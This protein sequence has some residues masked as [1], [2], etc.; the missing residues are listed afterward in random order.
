MIPLNDII[1]RQYYLVREK[2]S[3]CRGLHVRQLLISN[4]QGGTFEG[5]Y[6]FYILLKEV[7]GYENSQNCTQRGYI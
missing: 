5:R 7:G 2:R 3:S 4:G 1:A 6:L